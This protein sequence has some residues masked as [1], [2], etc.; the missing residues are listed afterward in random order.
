MKGV[1]LA[2]GEGTRLFP[3][4]SVVNKHLLP[5]YNKPMIFYP[6]ETLI[7]AGCKEILVVTG[8]KN[9]GE[10]LKLLG[11]GKKFGLDSILYAYQDKAGGIPE[12]LHLAKSFVG[13]EKFCLILGDNLIFDD[14]SGHFKQFL[15]E[16]IGSAK[17][18]IKDVDNPTSFGVAEIKNNK[19][20]S[21]EEKPKQPKSNFAIIGVYFF[22]G[23]VFD[24]IPTLKPSARGELEIPDVIK[25][26]IDKNQ[27][28]YGK[29]DFKWLDTG[30]FASLQEANQIIADYNKKKN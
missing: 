8:S 5:I 29:L 22:D 2:G 15:N 25:H 13:N 4:T 6:L 26:Y 28:T 17:V 14:L 16:P 20:I 11:N 21:V 18:F 3:C 24:I 12:A 7:K 9:P 30:S 27:L 10:F 19:I 23:T 1:I